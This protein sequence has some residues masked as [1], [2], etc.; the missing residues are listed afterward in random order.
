M[1]REGTSRVDWGMGEQL[2]FASL[3]DQKVP[4]RLSGQDSRRGT[5][6]QRHSIFIDQQNGR[7]YFPLA[8]YQ[9][10][11]EV[12]DSPLSEYAVLGFEFGYSL[13]YPSALV[14]FEAQ[15]GDFING[16]QII[17]D[18]YLS[19]SEQKWAR[20]SGLTLLLPHGFEG[21]GPEHSSG[22]LERFLQLCASDNIQVAN[23][24]TPAQYFHLLRRQVL[25][26]LRRPLIVFTP[27]GLL[28]HPQATSA[29]QEF[30]AHA[31]EE[32]IGE[33]RNEATRLLLCSG[34]VYYDLL[35]EREKRGAAHVALV[36]IEQLFP[37]HEK[38][39]KEI[40]SSFPKV[41][42]YFWVQEEPQNMGAGGYIAPLL[43]VI[44]PVQLISRPPSAASA[45]G[46]H[47]KHVSEQQEL[48]K[49]AFE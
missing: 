8:H 38:K 47:V 13:S 35:A 42:Q 1:I 34:R 46:S 24:T 33:E 39:L 5:F 10:E 3:L 16:A 23:P 19:A 44:V 25:R 12:V 45:A 6:S 48:M 15:Y 11:F 31:F 36:R 18:Q 28:R 32:I 9:A 4:V 17:I 30:T 21:Q 22:R 49:K 29:L 2:C 43:K 37:L 14:L 27:K 20:Y 26:P 40:L 7:E 41:Q